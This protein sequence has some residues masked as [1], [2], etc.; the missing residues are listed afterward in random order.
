M[1]EK[2]PLEA[3]LRRASRMAEN[4]FERDGEVTAFGSPRRRTGG[5]PP[6]RPSSKRSESRS[7]SA[8]PAT[9]DCGSSRPITTNEHTGAARKWA[10]LPQRSVNATD[11]AVSKALDRLR[12]PG[13]R[14]VLTYVNDGSSVTRRAYFILPGGHRVMD[15]TAQQLL[16]RGD[17]EPF[18]S[19]LLPGHPQS[20]KLGNWRTWTG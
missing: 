1:T 11:K 20:W 12:R 6:T 8:G 9:T 18:D 3:M 14:L 17:V 19:G 10:A 15:P 7:S 2:V 13:A 4:M 16:E 5:L